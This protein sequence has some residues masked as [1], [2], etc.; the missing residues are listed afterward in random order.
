M[1]VDL[2]KC[3]L[4]H[5]TQVRQK[6]KKKKQTKNPD[7]T[8]GKQLARGMA[9]KKSQYYNYPPKIFE[10]GVHFNPTALVTSYGDLNIPVKRQIV[11]L[12]EARCNC[13]L[14]TKPTFE[15]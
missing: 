11:K 9:K 8:N 12:D 7:G 3:N 10:K 14:S 13:I 15:Y 4:K 1:S 5:L 6:R 2:V